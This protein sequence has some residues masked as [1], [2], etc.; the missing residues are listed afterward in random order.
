ML[1]L[2]AV[3][4]N[5]KSITPVTHSFTRK[6]NFLVRTEHSLNM[7]KD[8]LKVLQPSCHCMN[9]ILVNLQTLDRLLTV[10][11]SGLKRSFPADQ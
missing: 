11:D 9:E 6:K 3:D 1:E 2:T 7:R 4:Q 8:K 10:D 5:P